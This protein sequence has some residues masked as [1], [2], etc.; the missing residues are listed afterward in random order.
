MIFQLPWSLLCLLQGRGTVANSRKHHWL[1]EQKLLHFV[2]AFHQYVMDRVRLVPLYIWTLLSWGFYYYLQSLTCGHGQERS[3]WLKDAWQITFKSQPN[4]FILL[5]YLVYMVVLSTYF[6][7]VY[8]HW[9]TCPVDLF[10]SP[11]P[12]STLLFLYFLIWNI[13]IFSY[14]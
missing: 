2:D 7:H 5:I 6:C 10:I 8:I 12:S 4:S 1:V 11:P 14:N 9:L 13:Y 3:L